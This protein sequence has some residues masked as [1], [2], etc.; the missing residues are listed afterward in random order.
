MI[1]S[2]RTK[3]I[4]SVQRCLVVAI[5]LLGGACVL[6]AQGATDGPADGDGG[7]SSSS[8]NPGNGGPEALSRDSVM[9]PMASHRGLRI[10]PFAGMMDVYDSQLTDIIL[11]PNG[12]VPE[13]GA[14]GAE[15]EAGLLGY[16]AYR[17]GIVGINY[18]GDYRNHVNG[19]FF[20]GMDHVLAVDLRHQI[21]K[22]ITLAVQES[23][24]S[25][26][27]S[28]SGPAVGGFVNPT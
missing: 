11:T 22:Y 9:G 4:L 24:G 10:R 20:N 19:H 23:L 27:R 28:F 1:A 8:L 15:A 25:Y 5:A 3:L 18:R 7:E 26:A 2:V 17:H 13:V 14:Y 12:E 16:K 6:H 21:S